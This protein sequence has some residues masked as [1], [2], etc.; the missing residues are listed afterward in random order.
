MVWAHPTSELIL[1]NPI[2]PV[3]RI[4]DLPNMLNEMWQHEPLGQETQNAIRLPLE[5]LCVSPK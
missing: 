2:T 4:N 5:K 3:W 1:E